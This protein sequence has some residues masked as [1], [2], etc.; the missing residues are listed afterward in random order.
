MQQPSLD[1]IG[2]QFAMQY[3]DKL[4][5]ARQTIGSFFHEQA[6]MIY[7]GVEAVGRDAIAMK[8]MEL[9]CNTLNV[10]LTSVD[11]LSVENSLVILVCGQLQCDEDRP[12]SFCETFTLSMVNG[13]FLVSNSIFRLNIHHF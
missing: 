10:F 1:E 13:C 4:K 9:K 6:R 7:E 2:K 8:L 5:T 3:Y 11:T 12:L